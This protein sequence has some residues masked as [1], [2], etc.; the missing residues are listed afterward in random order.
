M[1][2]FNW[3]YVVRQTKS[4]QQI[5]PE[6]AAAFSGLHQELQLPFWTTTKSI[7]NKIKLRAEKTLLEENV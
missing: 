4:T 2:F 7:F 3:K 1:Q 6:R 5:S